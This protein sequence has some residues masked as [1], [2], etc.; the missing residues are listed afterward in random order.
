MSAED[1]AEAFTTH[2]YNQRKVGSGAEN[3]NGLFVSIH[4]VMATNK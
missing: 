2:Y 4:A 1:V 3:I